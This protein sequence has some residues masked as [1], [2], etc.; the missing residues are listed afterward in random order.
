METTGSRTYAVAHKTFSPETQCRVRIGEV[1]VAFAV[2]MIVFS[3][4]I[5]G[6]VQGEPDGGMT[7]MSYAAQSYAS[8]GVE[9]ARSAQ[10]EPR[11][12]PVK[13]YYQHRQLTNIRCHQTSWISHSR[14]PTDTN[15]P[16]W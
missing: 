1:L 16:F 7:S 11:S 5:Y 10:W 12:S 2:L 15:F 14:Q 6:Y 4:L 13:D 8:E 9:L 3:G